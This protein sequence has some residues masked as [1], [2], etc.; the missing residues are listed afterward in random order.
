MVT[1]LANVWLLKQWLIITWLSNE[2][3]KKLV[4]VYNHV[5]KRFKVV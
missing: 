2:I 5:E 3:T 4:H 1:N